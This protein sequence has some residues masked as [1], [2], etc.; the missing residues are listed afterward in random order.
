MWSK[1]KARQQEAE[2]RHV[3]AVKGMPCGVCDAPPPSD[4]HEIEQGLWF[5]VIPL[6]RDCHQGGHNGI[7]GE[8][9]IWRVLKKT[10]HGVLNE[11]I[12]RLYSQ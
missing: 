12:R 10:E 8:A 6:C 7:H 9:R 2:G 4:A 11:T 1:H 5:L 3:A